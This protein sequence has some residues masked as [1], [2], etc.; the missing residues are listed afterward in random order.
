MRYFLLISIFFASTSLFANQY[1]NCLERINVT[2]HVAVEKAQEV[3]RRDTEDCFRYPVGGQYYNCQDK[4]QEKY[5]KAVDRAD[6]ILKQQ[7]KAC[8]KYPWI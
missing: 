8:M 5:Q 6:A 2:H 1:E 7:H 4:A 3:L